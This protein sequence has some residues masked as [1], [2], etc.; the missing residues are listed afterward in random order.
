LQIVLSDPTNAVAGVPATITILDDDVPSVSLAA[1]PVA[2]DEPFGPAVVTAMLNAASGRTVTVQYATANGT[3]LEGRD[4]V[5]VL[6]QLKFLPGQTTR[7]I[8]IPILDDTTDEP[9]ETFQVR[10]YNPTNAALGAVTNTMVVIRDDD[11]PRASFASSLFVTNESAGGALISVVLGSAFHQT[12]TVD[13]QTENGTAE[14]GSD[15][16]ATA[17]TV[18]FSPSQTNRTFLVPLISD[19][20]GEAI[21]TVK[22]KLTGY[23]NATPG[24]VTEATLYLVDNGSPP[25]LVAPIRLPDRSFQ[26]Q[27]LSPTG[28]VHA[29]QVTTNLDAWTEIGRVTNNAFS[30]TFR[31]AG[32]TNA[33]RRIYRA[34]RP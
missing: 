5:G 23:F 4:Y 30:A 14:A 9:D 20:N 32:A 29:I 25:A 6:E 1:G 15:Y 24:A 18:I 11:P 12:V 22:L 2:V 26:F 33:A 27:V 17:T 19:G 3:A 16:Q 34:Q 8:E 13:V 28:H 21:E 7:T 10:I 31:D